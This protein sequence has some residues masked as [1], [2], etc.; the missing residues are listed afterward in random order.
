MLEMWNSITAAKHA[1]LC[2]KCSELVKFTIRL[3]GCNRNFGV[4]CLWACM[5]SV[6]PKCMQRIIHKRDV[7][8]FLSE[9]N[10]LTKTFTNIY[11]SN[12]ENYDWRSFSV[13]NYV[14]LFVIMTQTRYFHAPWAT[15]FIR[16]LYDQLHPPHHILANIIIELCK[17]CCLTIRIMTYLIELPDVL[18]SQNMQL[19]SCKLYAEVSDMR[20]FYDSDSEIAIFH[21]ITKNYDLP[22]EIWTL[23]AYYTFTPKYQPFISILF[24]SNKSSLIED[25]N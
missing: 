10:W 1:G 8:H 18:R 11:E 2:D 6:H 3:P 5:S 24:H 4:G 20:K 12:Y 14:K 17:C 21:L 25:D 23:T 22:N 13:E 7:V 19:I 9:D 15:T 16:F